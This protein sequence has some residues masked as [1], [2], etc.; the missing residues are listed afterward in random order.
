MFAQAP[1]Q[2]TILEG[3]CGLYCKQLSGST[4]T[5]LA[6]YWMLSGSPPHCL[7]DGCCMLLGADEGTFH[8]TGKAAL[9]PEA[10]AAS[11]T[12]ALEQRSVCSTPSLCLSG[13][14]LPKS[15]LRHPRHHKGGR[16]EGRPATTNSLQVFT[17][18]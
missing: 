3:N 5:S 8:I 18:N 6:P 13:C 15:N 2:N 7:A 14:M 1:Q 12:A 9:L 16:V 11:A 10:C 4:E 17:P